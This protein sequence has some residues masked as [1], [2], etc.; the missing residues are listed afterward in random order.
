[1]G[2]GL[3]L[4]SVL[5]SACGDDDGSGRARG[6]CSC[7][8]ALSPEASDAALEFLTI[9]LGNFRHHCYQSSKFVEVVFL[10][11]NKRLS[12]CRHL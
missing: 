4:C 1:V 8:A 5:P 7:S 9:L 3:L 11:G 10:M 6:P 12:C 2:D